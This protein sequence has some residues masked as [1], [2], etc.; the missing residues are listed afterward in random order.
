MTIVSKGESKSSGEEK[1]TVKTTRTKCG[2]IVLGK[3]SYRVEINDLAVISGKT[4]L[5]CELEDC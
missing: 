2:I 3:L 5:H 1:Y 4:S